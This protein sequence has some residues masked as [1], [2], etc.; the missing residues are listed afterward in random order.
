[1]IN[2][3]VENYK[4]EKIQLTNSDLCDVINITGLNPVTANLIMTDLAGTDGSSY[5]SGRIPRRNIVITLSYKAPIENNRNR[6]YDHFPINKKLRLYFKT[7]TKNVWIDGYTEAN[8]V[9]LFSKSEQS[10][11]S[12]I[13]P[14]PFFR[15]GDEIDVDFSG[16]VALFE[17]PFAIEAAGIEFSRIERRSSVVINA[18]QIS[19]GAIF[20]LTARTS[21]ILNP[22][23]YNETTNEYFGLLVDMDQGDVITINTFKG[24]KSAILRRGGVETNVVGRRSIGSKWLQLAAG[25]NELSYSC[26]EGGENLSVKIMSA[27][28]YEGL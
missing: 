22:T 5:N 13:C 16:T 21:Q 25:E 7:E 11:I 10:Q 24:E 27:A 8:E 20:T 6:I 4:G 17:F 18:G 15:S 12:I 2:V 23:I 28:C 14:F 19:T 9:G 3:I 1:M 26:D